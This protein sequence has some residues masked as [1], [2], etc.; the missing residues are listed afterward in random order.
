MK[1]FS[2]LYE[3][4]GKKPCELMCIGSALYKKM[5]VLKLVYLEPVRG[6]LKWNAPD[7]V[8]DYDGTYQSKT[9]T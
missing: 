1:N 2:Q 6:L 8:T 9:K 3:T 7:I 5:K 4:W